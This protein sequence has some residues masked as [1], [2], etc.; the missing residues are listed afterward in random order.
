MRKFVL[1]MVAACCLGTVKAQEGWSVMPEAGVTV[2]KRV[3][4]TTWHP[5]V[6]AGVGVDYTFKPGWIGIK[7]GLY[8]TNRGNSAPTGLEM[9]VNE[10]RIG[11]GLRQG[12]ITQHFLQVPVVADFSWQVN[13]RW[14]MH[15]EAGMY[16][17]YAVKNDWEWG[18]YG[19][20]TWT[21]VTP[22]LKEVLEKQYGYLFKEGLSGANGTKS[23]NDNPYV[24]HSRFDWG[25]T[26]GIG[27]EVDN[28]QFKV[29]YELS[30]GDE[31]KPYTMQYA[32][33]IKGDYYPSVGA[34]YN[35]L[36]WTLGYR[37]KMGK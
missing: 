4:G 35:T 8:Y 5:A 25:V 20:T 2:S 7:S 16:A 30:L 23:G 37:F 27:L 31:G 24:G 17:A 22:E 15:F 18:D 13:D 34:N 9:S 14:R 19:A 6:R 3:N 10:D 33:G 11:C 12:R 28:W 36:M 1:M 32:P 26:T 29:G 21:A